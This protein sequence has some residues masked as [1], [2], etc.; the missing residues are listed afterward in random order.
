MSRFTRTSGV[1]IAAATLFG[2]VL[3]IASATAIGAEQTATA[4]QAQPMD[5]AAAAHEQR[6]AD[7]GERRI[8]EMHDRLRITPAQEDAWNKVA[9]VMRDN[10][11][12]FRVTVGERYRDAKPMSA[13][14]DLKS[15]QII[16]DEHS[17][18]LKK[19]IPAFD[20][21][22]G[23]MTPDQQKRADSVFAH[24]GRHAFN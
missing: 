1:A 15:F 3:A 16:A 22:Y 8:R 11:A 10:D 2:A 7:R 5:A 12:A 17:N 13:V 19:L 9:K 21:L 4:T 18:G 6:A 14:D 23:A 20:T 24:R